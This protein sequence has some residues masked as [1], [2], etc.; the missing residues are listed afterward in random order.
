MSQVQL[1]LKSFVS[2][3][4]NCALTWFVAASSSF[5]HLFLPY[6]SRGRPMEMGFLSKREQAVFRLFESGSARFSLVRRLVNQT[7]QQSVSQ[8]DFIRILLFFAILS[9][10]VIELTS[11]ARARPGLKVYCILID[12]PQIKSATRTTIQLKRPPP[13]PG[14]HAM[15]GWL[16]D[17]IVW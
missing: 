3:D 1:Q 15:L 14:Y 13:P 11:I 5:F 4:C 8:S 6:R 9:R 12:F 10:Y 2:Q 7:N 17:S 16:T